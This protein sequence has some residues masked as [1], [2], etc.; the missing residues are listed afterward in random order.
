MKG[1]TIFAAILILFTASVTA[2]EHSER[3][4]DDRMGVEGQT[5]IDKATPR[6]SLKFHE[7]QT[8]ESRRGTAQASLSCPDGSIEHTD[9]WISARLVGDSDSRVPEEIAVVSDPVRCPDGVCYRMASGS[10]DVTVVNDPPTAR[11][12]PIYE[13]DTQKGESALYKGNAEATAVI[14]YGDFSISKRSARTG[15]NP[16]TGKEIQSSG[17]ESDR[18]LA[19]RMVASIKASNCPVDGRE[20]CVAEA[21]KNS[22]LYSDLSSRGEIEILMT[23]TADPLVVPRSE[24]SGDCDDSDIDRRPGEVVCGQTTHFLDPDSDGDGLDDLTMVQSGNMYEWRINGEKVANATVN[25]ARA[26]DTQVL[27]L[28]ADSSEAEVSSK[29][30]LIEAMAS[31]SGLSKADSKKA[32]DSFIDATLAVELDKSSPYLAKSLEGSTED[33]NASTRGGIDKASPK[34]MEELAAKDARI[35]ELEERI[36]ELESEN[37]INSTAKSP[38][39]NGDDPIVR[40]KPGRASLDDD[41]DGDGISDTVEED[42]SDELARRPGFIDRL[43]S[44]FFGR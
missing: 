17:D 19:N 16:Q 29:P 26:A 44:S 1:K 30:E 9:D 40:K 36:R 43:F 8:Y 33:S 37:E 20:R 24:G 14:G 2:L 23:L 6:C 41:S 18:A 15:R 3:T 5:E 32:L 22:E 42:E 21:V 39:E 27:F 35:A 11:E 4:P 13:G 34:L 25:S 28:Q 38:Q 7:N 10:I 12:N 31:E